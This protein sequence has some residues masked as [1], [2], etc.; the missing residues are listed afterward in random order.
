MLSVGSKLGPYE[1]V[2]A[3]GAGGM[4][5]VYRARDSRLGRDVA[6]KVLNPE[7]VKSPEIKARFEREAR[8]ISAL[9]HPHICVLHDI[10]SESGTEY[11]VMEYLEGETLAARLSKGQ[12][13]FEQLL[14]IGIEIADALEKAHRAGIV[15]RDLK[16]GNIMLTK[17]GAKLLDFG[18]AKPVSQA[19]A[20]RQSGSTPSASVFAAAVTMTS[21]ASPLTSAGTIVGTMQ[22]MSPEQ[23]QGVEADARS[24]IFSFGAILYEMAT[25]RRAFDRK[26][27]ASV[28]A[29]I[30]DSEPQPISELRPASLP[31]FDRLV[32]LCLAKDRDDR[33]QTAHDVMLQLRAIAEGGSTVGIPAAVARRRV[34]REVVAWTL[35]AAATIVAIAVPA[36]KRAAPSGDLVQFSVETPANTSLFPFDTKG[37][38]ISPDGTKLALVAED[39]QGNTSLYVRDLAT[40]KVT[41]LPGTDNAAY[42]F[43]SPDSSQLGFFANQKLYRINAKGGSTVALCEAASGRGG[44]WSR[45]DVI[46]F[47]PAL[48]G[49]LY[50]VAAS[51]GTPERVT[52][53]GPNELRHRWPWFLPNDKFLY[54][55]DSDL[56]AGSLDGKLRKRLLSNVSNAVFAPP[57]RLVFSRGAVLMSQRFDPDALALQGDAV[58][59]PFGN[60][61][62]LNAKALSIIS[63]SENGRLAFLPQPDSVSRLVWVDTKGREEGEVGEAG[64]ND[65]AALSPDGKRIAVVRTT[66][67]GSD[68]WLLLT[69][70]NRLTRFTF[71]PGSYGFPVWSRDSRQLAFFVATGIYGQ[72]AIKSLDG[73]E[74]SPVLA[75]SFWQIPNGFSPDGSRIVTYVQTATGGDL[76]TLSLDSK[77]ALTPF[78]NSP[79]DETAGAFSPDGKWI[80]Y[81]SNASLRNEIYVRRYPPTSEQW[82]ISN[83][84]GE[85]PV[86]SLDGKE[87]FYSAG[88]M[89]MHVAI[90]GGASL[91]PG[92]PTT[93]FR[94]PGHPAARLTGSVAQPTISG[95]TPDKQHFLFRLATEQGM[96]SI[97]VVLNWQKALADR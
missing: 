39:P 94:I 84:G 43:W 13:P 91:S 30:L 57:D 21:P 68:I 62:F 81:Q 46:L 55:A 4:G 38:A 28:I 40:M 73:A 14:K 54:I 18:L 47:A 23:V 1:I 77:P 58:P 31:A 9:Q 37:M 90:G 64:A 17:A 96:P 82:Q 75:T 71:H 85:N 83:S 2:G 95:I 6:I 8:A 52:S 51:G 93:L 16:P 56:F 3:L 89:I 12:L 29:A 45:N 5:E 70:D 41:A 60:V 87:L 20:A 33:W 74:R 65:D 48:K 27:A 36:I 97:N 15:H 24:D 10:G 22:Y 32:Q 59:L 34:R 69:A 88:N 76:Y 7:L 44:T 72:V 53:L 25:G 42:P 79:F 67:D 61:A 78:V 80:A 50:R 19:A 26:S 92:I 63:A 49:E 86:W 66:P 11:L 35:A